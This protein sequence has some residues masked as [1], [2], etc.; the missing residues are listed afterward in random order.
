M[1]IILNRLLDILQEYTE[2]DDE[3]NLI[4]KIDTIDLSN[5]S[6]D[7][8]RLF[9]NLIDR[10]YSTAQELSSDGRT[11]ES[12]NNALSILVAL[13]KYKALRNLNKAKNSGWTDY[14]N[15]L[16][17]LCIEQHLDERLKLL[18]IVNKL[19]NRN[20]QFSALNQSERYAIAGK[21]TQQIENDFGVD[22][23]FFG[24]MKGAGHFIGL[25][26]QNPEHLNEMINLIPCSGEI[27][28]E[29]Y[30]DIVKAFRVS[31]QNAEIG[32]N[33]L[34]PFTRLLAM[35]RP[36]WF[37]CITGKNEELLKDFLNQNG[38]DAGDYE[39]YWDDFLMPIHKEM[40]WYNS[41]EPDD[42]F[43]KK[44]WHYRIA[45][46][47]MLFYQD[48]ET[49]RVQ[50]VIRNF[51]NLID[52]EKARQMMADYWK[53]INNQKIY[54]PEITDKRE[55]IIELISHRFNPEQAFKIASLL[56]E[57]EEGISEILEKRYTEIE[58]YIIESA[59]LEDLIF[60]QAESRLN[61]ISATNEIK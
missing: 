50:G 61:E 55:L 11:I 21:N 33:Y 8:F 51:D 43:E 2:S 17:N 30:L 35:K 6:Q 60:E 10:V 22:V 57:N 20:S 44:L 25:V 38:L 32:R 37:L 42:E 28:K 58:A 15:D 27:T 13:E 59:L 41:E 7:E 34:R 36:D 47:D 9:N 14:V 31:L 12:A 1:S 52:P 18:D 23:G 54:S 29:Q 53:G 4:N 16:K 40:P 56:L 45:L 26:N 48:P 49:R 19:F 3:A 46:L 5:I 39:R 24:S